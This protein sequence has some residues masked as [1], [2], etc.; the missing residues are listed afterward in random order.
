MNLTNWALA[1]L[2]LLLFMAGCAES[3]IEVEAPLTGDQAVEVV[4]AFHASGRD[5]V[6]LPP[7]R[8]DDIRLACVLLSILRPESKALEYCPAAL[9]IAE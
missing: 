9:L 7:A 6:S 8:Q 5:Y 2:A 1:P 4:E 3:T